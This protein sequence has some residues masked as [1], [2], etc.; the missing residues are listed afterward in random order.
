[1][2]A[3]S[4]LILPVMVPRAIGL[5]VMIRVIASVV[6][7]AA[8]EPPGSVPAWPLGV[9]A[10][11]GVVGLIDV[12]FR[13]ESLLWAHLGATRVGICTIYISV[14][15]AFEVVLAMVLR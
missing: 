5:W 7:L 1:M 12:V 9:V 8:G 6:P 2:R 11:T 3:L 13:R 14:A 10:L 15:V 4:A